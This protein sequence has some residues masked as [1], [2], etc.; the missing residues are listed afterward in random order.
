MITAIALGAFMLHYNRVSA[1]F[2]RVDGQQVR[3]EG[4]IL[5]STFRG[6]SSTYTILANFPDNPYLP[7]NQRVR[8]H[9]FRR[10]EFLEGEVI[11]ATI[12]VSLPQHSGMESFHRSREI[13]ALGTVALDSPIDLLDSDDH[14]WW[15][16][17]INLRNDMQNN[18]QSLLSPRSS[19]IIGAMSLGLRGDIDPSL[20]NA[21]S[22]SGTIHLLTVSGL[23][24]SII[25]AVI[26]GILER[27]R[28]N[29]VTRNLC[30]ILAALSFAALVGFSGP[31]VRAFVMTIIML[32]AGMLSKKHDAASALGLSLLLI[33]II[34]PGW[35]QGRGLWLSAGATLGILLHGGRLTEILFD[36]FGVKSDRKRDRLPG[37]LV[38]AMA[39]SLAA[40]TFS[41]PI[42]LATNG[43]FA[44][45]SP[46]AN[47]LVTPFVA[48]AMIS[49]I[50]IAFVGGDSLPIRMIAAATEVCADMI[51]GIS[52]AISD[53]PFATISL[54]QG[55]LLIVLAGIT[56][57]VGVL[58]YFK[59][60]RELVIYGI[61]LSVLCLGVGSL[62]M[63]SG[64]RNRV[65]LVTLAGSDGAIVIRDNQAVI[66][67]SPDRGDI[68]NLLRY[69]NFRGIRRIS[70]V[71]DPYQ[72]S[73]LDS[74]MVRLFSEYQVDS[75]IGPDDA[76][77]LH[78][79][80]EA[81]PYTQVLPG[82]YARVQALDGVM[83][84]T[85][86]HEGDISMNIGRRV[87]YLSSE[88]WPGEHPP[89][90][91]SIR[92]WSYG[93]ITAPP[94]IAPAVEPMGR[95]LFGETRIILDIRG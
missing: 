61:M 46:I 4:F 13:V 94:G 77:I 90:D 18:L 79:L 89:G 95:Y 52:S 58:V 2:Y 34:W 64:S 43:W 82:G 16:L 31:V 5:E 92:I 25:T 35:T 27:L 22:R 36:V 44:I 24:L 40:Y 37:V 30:A 91:N 17:W 15:L 19:Q 80:E 93:Y 3:V 73:R 9:S 72:G 74:G 55:Y 81:L 47:M 68:G 60:K 78:M 67:G 1:P 29:V 70:A 59:A 71:I 6:S 26:I 85:D 86:R 14:Q 7:G 51:I 87:V 83:I 54:D 69:L 62:T 88:E 28:V 42:L 65:E 53:L 33:G 11:G 50:I 48:P 8:I 41:L 38:E 21:V 10:L 45:L 23:H 84:L 56:A 63:A 20:M 57:I 12:R 66:L 39:I 32:L 75:M 49:G 76:Y